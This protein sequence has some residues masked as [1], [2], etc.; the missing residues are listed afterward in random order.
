MSSSAPALL[1]TFRHARQA[2]RLAHAYILF[3]PEGIGKRELAFD[4]ARLLLCPEGGCNACGVCRRIETFNHADFRLIEREDGDKELKIEKIR[5]MMREIHLAPMEGQNKV[6]VIN[7]CHLMNEESSNA[8]LKTLEEPPANSYLFLLTEMPEALIDT[9]RSRCQEFRVPP[10]P[11]AEIASLLSIE[12]GITDEESVFLAKMSEGS[13]G[14]ARELHKQNAHE[15]CQWL[16]E[17]FQT[18]NSLNELLFAGEFE[19]RIKSAGGSKTENH[20][21]EFRRHLPLI[22]SFW[23]D[24]LYRA[25]GIPSARFFHSDA[26]SLGLYDQLNLTAPRALAGLELS[27]EAEE[28]MRRNA[29]F[30]LAIENYSVELSR[31]MTGN[32]H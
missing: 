3:G 8:L 24:M 22:N 31:L 29:N 16:L 1:D 14:R 19:A 7:E 6:F 21:Q 25:L 27:F 11:A 26:Q 9:I 12:L 5:E 28:W 23:R 18:L 10:K 20:R 17:K 30:A 2:G 15:T 13:I 32:V 4:A